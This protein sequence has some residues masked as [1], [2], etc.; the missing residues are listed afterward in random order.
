MRACMYEGMVEHE[1]FSGNLAEG[2]FER[3]EI[4]LEGFNIVEWDLDH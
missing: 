1:R 2:I 3:F 4:L